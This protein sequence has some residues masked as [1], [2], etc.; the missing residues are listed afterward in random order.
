MG[1]WQEF[2]QFAVKGN[3]IDL[4]V[5]VIIGAAFG[6]ITTSLVEDVIMPPLGVVLGKVDFSS[7][8]VVMPGQEDKIAKA[9]AAAKSLNSYSDYKSS[10]IAVL[11]YGQFLNNVIQFLI[12][13]FAVFLLVRAINH[14][15]A[16]AEPPPA[17]GEP[18]TKDCP[19]CLQTIPVKATRCAHCTSELTV[20]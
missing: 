8:F 18:V 13:A 3:V 16:L 14:M 1:L 19:F 15:K 20:A 6:K 9:T 2:K 17:A 7:L 4:A 12:V 5:G 11:S 10:G